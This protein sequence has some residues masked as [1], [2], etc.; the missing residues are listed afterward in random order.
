MAMWDYL[1]NYTILSHRDG[2]I[3]HKVVL[4]R[5]ISIQAPVYVP[6]H[7]IPSPPYP[8]LHA[9]VKD[10]SVLIHEAFA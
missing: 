5:L 9:H 1:Y 8:V 6:Q 4:D 3:I 7:V 10:P 2:I